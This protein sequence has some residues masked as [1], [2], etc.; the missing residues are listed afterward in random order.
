MQ[1][2]RSRLRLPP[3][4]DQTPEYP[5]SVRQLLDDHFEPPLFQHRHE[6]IIHYRHKTLFPSAMLVLAFPFVRFLNALHRAAQLQDLRDASQVFESHELVAPFPAAIPGFTAQM[7]KPLGVELDLRL[8]IRT[9]DSTQTAIKF[10]RL[11]QELGE[12]VVTEIERCHVRA[13]LLYQIPVRFPIGF[14]QSSCAGHA[15]IFLLISPVKIPMDQPQQNHQDDAPQRS[16]ES[17]DVRNVSESFRTVPKFSESFG[18]VPK[19]SERKEN[20]SLTVREAAKIFE[21]AGVARTERSI[22]NWCQ[23]NRQGL[24]RLDSYFDPN[25]RKYYITPESV[26]LAIA[27]EKAKAAKLNEPSEPVGSVPKDAEKANDA[28]EPDNDRVKELERENLDLKITNRGKDF[29]IEQMEK[30]RNGF[31]D[32]LLTANRKMGELE[33]RLLG[34]TDD[35]RSP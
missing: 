22:T 1:H 5:C 3:E 33:T 15:I 32:Q 14:P 8:K 30:E 10:L 16:E 26:E 12:F 35:K 18:N 21:A 19:V 6:F 29:L 9:P 2:P 4:R 13:R 28:S 11:M 27:E 7:F 25:E 24:S 23:P 34:I 31:F 20:H 17:G